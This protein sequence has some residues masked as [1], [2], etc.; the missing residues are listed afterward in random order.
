M[1]RTR[2]LCRVAH[3]SASL[4]QQLSDNTRRARSLPCAHER[5]TPELACD[6]AISA[7]PRRVGMASAPHIHPPK[8]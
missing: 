1:A 2:F 8:K 4:L 3:R 7:A 6:V 5:G